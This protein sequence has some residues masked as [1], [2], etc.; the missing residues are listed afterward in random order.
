MAAGEFGTAFGPT[1]LDETGLVSRTR[2]S[3]LDAAPQSRDPLPV[4]TRWA[5]AQQRTTPQDRPVETRVNALMV[6]HCVRSTKRRS[7]HCFLLVF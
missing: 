3:V 6:L 2:C 7:W 4:L 1:R 5:P